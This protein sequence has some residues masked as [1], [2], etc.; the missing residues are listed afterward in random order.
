MID[1]SI[2]NGRPLDNTPNDTL[3]IWQKYT[4]TE[5]QLKNAWLGFGIRQQTSLMPLASNSSWGTVLP[6]WTVFDAAF[7]HRLMVANRALDLQLNIENL[8]DKL[9]SAGGRTWSPPRTFTFSAG[10]RF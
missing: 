5:G 2:L 9:Y 3:R 8:T 10:T 7:G 1:Y 6:G 4:F